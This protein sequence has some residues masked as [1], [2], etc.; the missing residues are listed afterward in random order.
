MVVLTIID[1]LLSVQEPSWDLV[2]S[3]VLHDLDNSFQF[4]LGQFT[5]SLVQINIS[6]LTNQVGV[7]TTDTS[8]GGQS[9]DNLDVT[10]NVGVQQTVKIMGIKML[11]K[12]D[13]S[14]SEGDNGG[15]PINTKC[16]S[17]LRL[18]SLVL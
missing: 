2:V 4:F 12:F 9:V 14:Q 17:L 8:D 6:L 15:K 18:C 11:V 5:S 10:I 3:W 13:D 1:I 16:F 7:S